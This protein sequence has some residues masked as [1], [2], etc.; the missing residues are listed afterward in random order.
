[1]THAHITAW[2]LAIILFFVGISLHNQQKD[3]AAN[4]VQM[5]L[6]AL[7]LVILVTGGYLLYLYSSID[8]M[9]YGMK[10]LLGI[11]LI[12]LMEMVLIRKGK[13]KNINGLLIGFFIV[14]V[15]VLFLGFKLPLG[16]KFF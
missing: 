4:I 1:M 11:V 2:L 15:I 14:F 13:G 9:L 5:I 7:Y 12:G 3:R 10:G 6:R 16:F 8:H